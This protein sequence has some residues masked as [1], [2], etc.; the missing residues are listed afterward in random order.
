MTTAVYVSCADSGEL[1]V[2]A[3]DAQRGTLE[4]RQV[5]ATGGLVMPIAIRPDRRVLYLARRDEPYAVLAFRIGADGRLEPHGRAPLP[6]SMAY[7]ATDASGRWLLAASYPAALVSVSPLEADGQAQPATQVLATGPKAHSIRTAA[8]DAFA[9]AAVL[10]SDEILQWRFDA[11][12]GR[13]HANDP[14]AQPLP[15][16]TGPRHLIFHPRLDRAYV[17]GELDGSVTVFDLDRQRGRLSMRQRVS[18]LPPWFDGEPWGAELRAT[19]DG[20]FVYASERRSS[21]IAGFA[22]DPVD[23]TLQPIGHWPA[24]AQPRGMA[25][26]P[27]G[28]WLIVA[29][30]LS[31]RV[32]LHRIDAASGALSPAGEVAVGR[33][34]NWVEA[35]LPG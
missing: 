9:F 31:H 25:V 30:Q 5:V 29:G 21:T 7:L 20:R 3:L 17:N 33:N 26:D 1:H 32:G 35:L 15:P 19:P 11:A 4:P 24:Q 18:A 16:G 23:G 28:R 27:S 10:G 6:A 12:A 22:V 14:P 8:D 13:L 2:L 34:P